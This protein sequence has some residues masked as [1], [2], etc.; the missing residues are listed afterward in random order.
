MLFSAE[1]I[2]VVA[3]RL[4][5]FRQ[6]IL[7]VDPVM[8]AKGGAN[9]IDHEA[10][11]V[12]KERLLPM[13]YLLTPNIPEAEALTGMKIVSLDDMMAAARVLRQS[14][15]RNIL[16][17]GGHGTE[18]ESVDLL[19]DGNEFSS[20]ASPRIDTLN[21]HGTGCTLSS[22]IATFL[23][24]GEPLP[25]AVAR[26]K[27]FITT[28]IRLALPLGQGHSPVNHFAAARELSSKE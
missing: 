11:S 19:Y 26:A 22:A 10:V 13:T 20:F 3:E 14:G 16:I 23:A 9:L 6:K 21:T 15:A 12:M 27:A 4:A 17:K 24:Q 18:A 25:V 8:I 2:R 7:I 1:I 28:A 5:F